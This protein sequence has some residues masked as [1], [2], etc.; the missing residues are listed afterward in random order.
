M[1]ASIDRSH[2]YIAHQ[3]RV[4]TNCMCKC[5]RA[6]S[7]IGKRCSIDLHFID[8]LQQGES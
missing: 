3:D 2:I 5:V 4:A 1:H 7:H 6:P 8:V